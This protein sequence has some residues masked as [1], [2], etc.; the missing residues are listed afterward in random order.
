MT[1]QREW[2]VIE[3]SMKNAVFAS[4]EQRNAKG[5][6]PKDVAEGL[7]GRKLDGVQWFS[8]EEGQLMRAHPEWRKSKP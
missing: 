4:D 7:L 3:D 6:I 8:R 5:Y 2:F 1:A